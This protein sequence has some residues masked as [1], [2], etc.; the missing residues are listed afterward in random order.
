MERLVAK[1]MVA[2]WLT[3]F[4]STTIL[5]IVPDT[6]GGSW[7]L[8]LSVVKLRVVELTRIKQISAANE[9]RSQHD[10]DNGAR[11]LEARKADK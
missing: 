4:C 8:V 6:S 11:E 1:N 9:H 10:V 3:N 2:A 7:H 5:H